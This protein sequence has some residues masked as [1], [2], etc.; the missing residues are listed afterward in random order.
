MH[1][2]V[3]ISEIAEMFGVSPPRAV[4]LSQTATFP[5]P[6]VELASGRVWERAS[7][8]EWAKGT[9]REMVPS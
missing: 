4:Q 9:G 8:E 7:V 6:T 1:H 5:T 2:L 3:G